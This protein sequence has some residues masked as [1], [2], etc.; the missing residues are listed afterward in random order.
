MR[1]TRA[2]TADTAA[3]TFYYL[4]VGEIARAFDVA[5]TASPKP[6]NGGVKLLEAVSTFIGD[7]GIFP[8]GDGAEDK[9]EDCRHCGHLVSQPAG[10]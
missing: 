5:E 9:G 10:G 6:G 4:L 8:Q 7:E 3:I 2:R 1:R